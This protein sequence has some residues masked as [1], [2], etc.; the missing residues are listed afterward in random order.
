MLSAVTSTVVPKYRSILAQSGG[1]IKLLKVGHVCF[2]STVV[3]RPGD[4]HRDPGTVLQSA[5]SLRERSF[6]FHAARD[7][8]LLQTW[9][10]G[11]VVPQARV[12]IDNHFL[13][14][15]LQSQSSRIYTLF[16]VYA[17]NALWG[18]L[19]TA[20][21]VICGTLI[22]LSIACICITKQIHVLANT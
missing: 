16:V 6:P 14:N 1:S 20:P 22:R 11:A 7:L 21:E 13:I 12:Q 17:H 15:W 4:H 10:R 2:I 19:I 9:W 18:R 5:L 3:L 8:R